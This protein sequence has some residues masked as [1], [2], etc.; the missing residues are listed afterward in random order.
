MAANVI[1]IIGG[2]LKIVDFGIKNFGNEEPDPGS[3]F[4]VAVALDGT[5]G[6]SNAGGDLPDM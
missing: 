5:G 6:T 2:L 3:E 1:G 4:R